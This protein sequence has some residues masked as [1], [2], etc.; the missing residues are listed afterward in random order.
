MNLNQTPPSMRGPP[1]MTPSA[2]RGTYR[3]A[4][5][6]D[7]SDGDPSSP[8]GPMKSLTLDDDDDDP[9]LLLANSDS[10]DSDDFETRGGGGS[11]NPASRTRSTKTATVSNETSKGKEKVGPREQPG[12]AAKARASASI[13]RDAASSSA[14]D[15]PEDEPSDASEDESSDASEYESGRKKNMKTKNKN[16]NKNKNNNNNSNMNNNNK[17]KNSNKNKKEEKKKEKQQK[18]K[19]NMRVAF[20]QDKKDR[21]RW[22]AWDEL[23]AGLAAH[24][25]GVEIPAAKPIALSGAEVAMAAEKVPDVGGAAESLAVAAGESANA[26]KSGYVFIPRALCR[27]SLAMPTSLPSLCPNPCVSS[28]R[29]APAQ[30][31]WC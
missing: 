29:Y 14:P 28:F 23:K 5:L 27:R 2:F 13:R 11:S 8:V 26:G 16:K 21:P 20:Q 4:L 9:L 31:H 30:S 17:N 25:S 1:T 3:D 10:D 24:K 12:R 15:A 7:Y 6:C 18:K 19:E 22:N